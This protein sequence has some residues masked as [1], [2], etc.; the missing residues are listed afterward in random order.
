MKRD[1]IIGKLL[2]EG[3]SA[4]TLVKF[5]DKQLVELASRIIS[6]GDVMISKKDPQYQQKIASAKKLNQSI[7]TYEEEMKKCSKK[8]KDTK[9]TIYDKALKDLGGEEGVIKFLETG[10]KPKKKKEVE[11][12]LKGGQKKLDKNHNGK[13]DGQ[14]FKILKGQKK[15]ISEDKECKNCGCTKSECKCKKVTKGHN[16]IPEF[17][18]SKK[19]KKEGVETKKWVE[20]LAEEKFFHILT[21]KNEI[22]EMIQ[23]KLNDQ[24][25]Q[26]KTELPDFLKWASLKSVKGKKE[27]AEGGTTTKPAPTKPKVAPGTKPKHPLSPGKFPKQI[28]KALAEKK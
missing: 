21:S 17:M 14:D 15:E 28:P 7:E 18:D 20:S 8:N 6:E 2:K 23:T 16:N 5:N 4:N 12:E 26:E 3:F 27:V 25:S 11:E 9:P 24:K 22:M 1:V 13:I 10:K 19:L